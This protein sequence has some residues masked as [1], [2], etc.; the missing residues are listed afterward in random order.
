M[1]SYSVLWRIHAVLMSASFLMMLAGVIINMF[2]KK[3]KNRIKIHKVLGYTGSGSGVI[4]SVLAVIMIGITHGYHFSNTHT[5]L[6]I[7]TAIL[8]AVVPVFSNLMLKVPGA[9]KKRIFRTAHVWLARVSLVMM[10]IVI[11]MGLRYAGII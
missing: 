7:I 2:F 10:A 6:G 4:A 8:L 11:V 9:G 1:G 5:I 3:Y